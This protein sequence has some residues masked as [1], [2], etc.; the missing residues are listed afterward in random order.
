MIHPVRNQEIYFPGA[1]PGSAVTLCLDVLPKGVNQNMRGAGSRRSDLSPLEKRFIALTMAGYSRQQRAKIIGISESTLRRRL[2]SI[3]DKL[4]VAGEL[5]L[6]LFALHYQ[7]L[8]TAEVSPRP[9]TGKDL[10]R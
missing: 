6:V 2:L 9:A 1:I 3:C 10:P 7:L 4:D 5:E 8:D